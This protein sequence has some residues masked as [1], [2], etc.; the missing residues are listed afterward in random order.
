MDLS[1]FDA[2]PPALGGS[3][4]EFVFGGRL[5][6]LAS[7]FVALEALINAAGALRAD[8]PDI[9]CIAL[10]DHEEV[11]S[12]STSGAGGPVMKEAISRIAEAFGGVPESE[13][14]RIGAQRSFI[15]S[16]DNAHAVHPNYRGK[17]EAAHRPLMGSGTVIKHNANQRYAT[18]AITAYVVRE[19]GRRADVGVQE[20]V[21]KNDCPCGSTIGPIISTL[22]GI[23]TCD[24]GMPQLSMH[25]C[26]EMMGA[27][28]LT[29]CHDLLQRFFTDFREVDNT[30]AKCPPCGE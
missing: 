27:A 20:F 13:A 25:S 5:D 10:F 14:V 11:G 17:H 8:D 6:N 15:L 26:R 28:D 30:L 12:S 1:L 3:H 18:D 16:L 7:S 4:S 2:N 19:L 21:V 29:H 23:R 22:V 24:I 9:C